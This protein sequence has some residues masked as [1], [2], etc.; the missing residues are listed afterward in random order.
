MKNPEKYG[1][2]PKGMLSHLVDIYLHLN[3][4]VLARAVA[5]DQRS[6]RKELF[7]TC[8]RLLEKIS[9]NSKVC[10]F[11]LSV[12]WSSVGVLFRELVIVITTIGHV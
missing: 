9:T 12:L 6:Y 8:T 11:C 2:D 1:F 5:E 4:D 3:S 10:V 7:D